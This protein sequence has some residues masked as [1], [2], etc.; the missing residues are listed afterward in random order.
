MDLTRTYQIGELAAR[1][2]L[3]L[4]TLR[5]WEEVGLITPSGR[6]VGGFRLYT[7][8]NAQRVELIMRMKPVDLSLDEL[9]VLADL[10]DR[11]ADPDCPAAERA[12]A[13]AEVEAFISRIRLRCEVLR[14]R[15]EEAELAALDLERLVAG[16]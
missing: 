9:K 1:V 10:R 3:S 14:G 8:A 15:I 7:E 13:A 12:R 2:H 11:L 16:G 5:Y 4:R 6:T